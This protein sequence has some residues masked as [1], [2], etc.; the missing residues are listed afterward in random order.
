MLCVLW[1]SKYSTY[2]LSCVAACEEVLRKVSLVIGTCPTQTFYFAADRWA[3]YCDQRVCVSVCWHISKITYP[4][5]TKFSVRDGCMWPCSFYP[6]GARYCIK[7]AKR[8]ITQVTPRDSPRTLVFWHQ[9]PL[10]DDP[11]PPEIFAQ[12]DPPTFQT[13]TFWPSA[14]SASTVRASEKSSISANR[15]WTTR[16]PT[17][18]KWTVYVTPKSH[19]GWHKT[20]FCYSFLANFKFC[21]KKSAA[22]FLRVKTSSSKIVASSFLYLT[23]HRGIAATSPSI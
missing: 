2:S 3:Q 23:V 10:M 17:S 18:H 7:R 1:T 20:R 15:K 16:F 6:R 22:K 21:R 11:L 5:F 12:S 19:T 13:P 4:N 8:R 14:H 9:E